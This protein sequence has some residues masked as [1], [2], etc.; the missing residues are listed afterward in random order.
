MSV[1]NFPIRK[2]YFNY[3]TKEIIREV[4]Y[5]LEPYYTYR[6]ILI[7]FF[8]CSY[9]F[10]EDNAATLDHS[11]CQFNLFKSP[12]K[13][14]SLGHFLAFPV[15]F[16][17]KD[18]TLSPTRESFSV[19]FWTRALATLILILILTWSNSSIENT[20]LYL[21]G[22]KCQRRKTSMNIRLSYFSYILHLPTILHHH[23]RPTLHQKE[24]CTTPPWLRAT[25]LTIPTS[26]GKI[27]LILIRN[28]WKN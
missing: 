1:S 5:T 26:R 25:M 23:T 24:S 8:V 27:K 22:I 13:V 17:L 20:F 12:S 4:S 9:P 11:P 21:V 19:Q 18:S 15:S 10:I 28:R 3:Q 6:D 2:F 16:C 7:F 14:F